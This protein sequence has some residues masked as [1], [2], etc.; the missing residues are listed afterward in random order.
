MV[1]YHLEYIGQDGIPLEMSI[2]LEPVF[3]DG[4]ISCSACG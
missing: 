1:R 4:T 3:P 2:G